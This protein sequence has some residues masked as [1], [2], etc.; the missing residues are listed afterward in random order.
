MPASL[1]LMIFSC[2]IAIGFAALPPFSYPDSV[3]HN[4]MMHGGNTSG[5]L[6]TATPKEFMNE[7]F[8]QNVS[9]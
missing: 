7:A 4:L 2:A 8:F 5:G 1:H 6:I 3:F 9:I